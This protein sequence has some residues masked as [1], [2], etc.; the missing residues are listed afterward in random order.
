M[1]AKKVSVTFMRY[2][3]CGMVATS[4]VFASSGSTK[5]EMEN[6]PAVPQTEMIKMNSDQL[7][8]ENE[9]CLPIFDP[10][11]AK[12]VG[13]PPALYNNDC[14][15]EQDNATKVPRYLCN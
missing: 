14:L 11:C 8:L 6:M 9:T 15:R 12:H 5:F 10:V 2:S 7:G 3:L 13:S 1:G 4:Q